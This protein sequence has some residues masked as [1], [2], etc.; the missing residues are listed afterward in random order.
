[1]YSV[2]TL[3]DRAAKE[4]GSRYRLAQLL[5]E[6]ESNLSKIATGKRDLSPRLAARMA[7]I[8]GDDPRDAALSSI[9]EHEQDATKRAELAR[10]F[11][12]PVSAAA[13]LAFVLLAF[14]GPDAHAITAASAQSE[15]AGSVYYVK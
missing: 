3:I 10:L 8:V 4:C 15:R 7:A 14:P 2:E 5:N 13:A 6:S 12:L 1:M 9:I 11:K